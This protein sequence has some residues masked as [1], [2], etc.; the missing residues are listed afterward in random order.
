MWHPFVS[1]QLFSAYFSYS[2]A[3]LP[4]EWNALWNDIIYTVFV[5]IILNEPIEMEIN[6]SA[7][8]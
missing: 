7:L 3:I 6:S 2:F 5:F 1:I 4:C 8:F